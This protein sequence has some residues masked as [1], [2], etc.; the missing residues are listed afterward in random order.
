LSKKRWA[1]VLAI[2]ILGLSFL[3]APLPVRAAHPIE[4]I[5]RVNTSQFAYQPA[6]IQVN[7]GDTIT[8][9]VISTDV[10]HGLYVEG[11]GV[12]VS[13]DPGQT[14]RLTF[15]ANRAGSFRIRCNEPCGALHP[16]MIGELKVGGNTGFLR[17]IGLISI[18]VLASV[19]A[20]PP[21]LTHPVA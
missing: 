19:V 4:R 1:F 3:F 13:V 7:P 20:V 21:R 8:L 11:Y 10:V 15:V 18:A 5:I 16:F 14:A 17:A 6:V 12:S 2:S 9:E